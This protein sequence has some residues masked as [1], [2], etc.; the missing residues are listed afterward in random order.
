MTANIVATI[1]ASNPSVKPKVYY[2]AN[3]TIQSSGGVDVFS[4]SAVLLYP[5]QGQVTIANTFINRNADGVNSLYCSDV[6]EL[7]RILDFRGYAVTAANS[8]LAVDVTSKYFFDSGQRNSIYDHASIRLKPKYTPPQGPISVSF[9]RFFSSGPGF[10]TVDSYTANNVTNFD[11]GNI[12][13]YIAPTIGAST[14]VYELRDCLDFRPVR[15]DAT[16]GSGSAV[17]FDVSPTTYG[18]KIPSIGTDLI[19]N[20]SY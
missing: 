19:L 4:N 17:T 16:A 14:A 12:P 20:Y 8:S 2:A 7:T 15:S 9:N 3:T 6:I 11:Y 1:F 13:N 5:T 18:P 10:F